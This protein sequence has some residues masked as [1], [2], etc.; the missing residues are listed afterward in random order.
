[1]RIYSGKVYLCDTGEETNLKDHNDKPFFT[2][3]IVLVRCSKS[4]YLSQD[5]SVVVKDGDDFFVM[6]LRNIC[7]ADPENFDGW[8]ILRVKSHKDVIDGEH[9]KAYGFSFRR[10]E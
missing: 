7:V 1:M 10:E 9:W 6:G 5:L 3:D 8:E 2:G 4:D